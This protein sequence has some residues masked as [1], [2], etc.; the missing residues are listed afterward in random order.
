MASAVAALGGTTKALTVWGI[1]PYHLL[2]Y[3]AVDVGT[4]IE[5]ILLA[6]A[7][8]NQ[9]RRNQR[10]RLRAEQMARLDP[11]TG[12]NNRRAF[13]EHAEPIWQ[14]AVRHQRPF[15]VAIIDLDEFKRINDQFGHK[16]GDRALELTAKELCSSIRT[17]DVLAR[18]G[19]EEFILLM[20]ETDQQ[21]AIRVAERL[22][23]AIHRIRI[24]EKRADILLSGSIGVANRLE[25]MDQLEQLIHKADQCLFKAKAEGRNRVLV[26]QA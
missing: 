19:G 1:I 6:L 24:Q 17:G 20:P 16:V 26:A 21:E 4:V 3:R 15:S 13:A 11:L 10:Q 9:F 18:W 7:L 14:K 2:G 12:L 23:M 25:Q 5:A 8:A 22:R